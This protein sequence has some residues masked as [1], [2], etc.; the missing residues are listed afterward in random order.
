M[1]GL[2]LAQAVQI[3]DGALAKAREQGYKPMTVAVV[4][5]GGYLLVLKREDGSGNLRPDIAFAKAWGAVGMGIGG[6]AIA[7]RAADSPAFWEALYT[8]SG[9]RIAPVA[10]G[11][12]VL[13]EGQVIGAVGMSGDVS[14]NDEACAIVGVQQAGFEAEVGEAAL[15][16]Q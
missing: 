1:R 13:H 2:T 7:K 4:D 12:L 16:K 5:P 10:G 3:A 14:D 15:G 9:G 11:V 8:I 6:R